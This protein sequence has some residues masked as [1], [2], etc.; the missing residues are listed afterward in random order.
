MN[1]RGGTLK[2]KQSL[3]H[4]HEYHPKQWEWNYDDEKI[5]YKNAFKIKFGSY[6]PTLIL[7]KCLHPKKE[8]ILHITRPKPSYETE[9]ARRFIVSCLNRLEPIQLL[10]SAKESVKYVAYPSNKNHIVLNI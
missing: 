9:K 6:L 5:T 4:R 10:L 3:P 2:Q 8:I 7:K 1:T